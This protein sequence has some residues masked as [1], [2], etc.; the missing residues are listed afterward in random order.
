MICEGKKKSQSVKG[1]QNPILDPSKS[2]P[3]T[4]NSS[5]VLKEFTYVHAHFIQHNLH[6]FIGFL[7]QWRVELVEEERP[8][9]SSCAGGDP[10]EGE[11]PGCFAGSGCRFVA[12]AVFN[13]RPF[14]GV[15]DLLAAAPIIM[16]YSSVTPCIKKKKKKK[17]K[18]KDTTHAHTERRGAEDIFVRR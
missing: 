15:F 17:K 14:C 16:N 7:R 8:D 11:A 12:S 3:A 1:K 10:P 18:K 2:T 9:S 4:L 13:M 5:I 6:V